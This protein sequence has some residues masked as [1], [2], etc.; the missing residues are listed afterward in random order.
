[1]I[2]DTNLFFLDQDNTSVAEMEIMIAEKWARGKR[3]GW[4]ASLLMMIYGVTNLKVKQ[5]VAKILS[6]NLISINMFRRM[7]FIETSRSAIFNEITL[8]II[9]DDNWLEHVKNNVSPF[10][11]GNY[12]NASS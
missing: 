5:F 3:C 7:G 1:M 10:V 8:E 11:I 4:E 9:V 12:T 2:G 6:N